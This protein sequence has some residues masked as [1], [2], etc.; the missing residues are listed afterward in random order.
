MTNKQRFWFQQLFDN[1]AEQTALIEVVDGEEHRLSY[2]QLALRVEQAKQHINSVNKTN[3]K[4][5]QLLMLLANNNINSIIYYLAALQLKHVVWWVDKDTTEQRLKSLQLHYGVNLYIEQGQI[6]LINS[7]PLTLHP[8]LA[9][10]ISTSGSTGSPTLVRLS[11]QNLHSN[12][13]DIW[14]ALTLDDSDHVLTTLPLQYS[15]GLSII[16]SHLYSGTTIVLN[17]QPLISREFWGLFKNYDIRCLYGVPYSYEMLLRLN[18]SRLPLHKLRFMA[19][20]GGKLSSDKVKLVGQY[21]VDHHL[22]FYV[23]YGQTEATA[24]I[25]VLDPQKVLIKPASVGQKIAKDTGRLWLEDEQG[26]RIDKQNCSGELCYSGDN[27]M[28][29]LAKTVADL[30]LPAQLSEL[31]TGDLAQFDEQGDFYIVGRLKRVIKLLGHRVNLDDVESYLTKQGYGVACSGVDDK[32]HCFIEG[33]LAVSELNNCKQVLADYL[34]IHS[35]YIS[36]IAVPTF[37]Y[38]A[39]GKLDYSA[40]AQLIKE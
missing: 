8:D 34:A 17:E 32:L 15:F 21:C 12:C 33:E 29:G 37:P 2:A 5:K 6:H 23:M 25:T 3:T 11:Y 9:V 35:T 20:A 40:L 4:T 18:L 16:N 10:L 14:A 13:V 39:S 26:L 27:V 24:R 28:M 31:K 7:T 22:Q 36:C 19:V 38:L 1:K 30:S